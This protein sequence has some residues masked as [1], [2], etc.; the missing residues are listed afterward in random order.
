ML[1][2]RGKVWWYR[3]KFHGAEV[4]ESAGTSSKTV[5][6]KIEFERR[7][8]LEEGAGGIRRRKPQ[9]FRQ[10]AEQWLA[11]KRPTLAPRSYRIE[12][13][14]LKHL[15]PVFGGM[16]CSD[17]EASD[18]ARYQQ[19]RNGAGAAGGTTNLEV[20]TLRAVLRR[21]GLWARIQPEVRMLPEGEGTGRALTAEEEQRL[22]KSC[23]AS[24]SRALY[25]AVV[26]ALNTGLRL[27][28]LTGLRWRQVDFQTRR[29]VV[30]KSKTEAGR[31]RPVPLNDRALAALR[32][33][34]ERF[35][36]REAEH[37]V[38][39]SEKYGEGGAVYATDPEKPIGRLK[40]AWEAA[41]RRTADEEKKIPAV[42]C[43][44]HDLRHTFCTRLLERRNGLPILAALMG[45]SPATTVRMAKRYG[46]LSTEVL[47][48]AVNGLD[49][50]L[51]EGKGA[52]EGARSETRLSAHAAN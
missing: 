42:L 18:V 52:Q 13:T 48:E 7:R 50:P 35:L 12:E 17:I 41:K 49:S 39:P 32:M 11:I 30:G 3:I 43:R 22:L 23:V 31:G 33:W 10:A 37:F 36:E 4:R 34:A 28:E 14:N 40:E 20:A 15:L 5:A 25:P 47:R 9:L 45:W 46:H 38:F 8:A 26:L 21:L 1:Y 44:W 29:L 2:K 24:R 19:R 27:S 16:L 51:F 6:R